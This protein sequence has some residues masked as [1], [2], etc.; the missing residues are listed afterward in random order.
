MLSA[1]RGQRP[2]RRKEARRARAKGKKHRANAVFLDTHVELIR[3]APLLRIF[4]L[5]LD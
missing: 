5:E 4:T 3:K 2:Q 1:Q